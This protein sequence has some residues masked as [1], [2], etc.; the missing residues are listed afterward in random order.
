MNK[1]IEAA[2]NPTMR[3]IESFKLAFPKATL[4]FVEATAERL[5]LAAKKSNTVNEKS[6]KKL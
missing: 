1:K 4:V 2:E 6:R 5:F 3:V